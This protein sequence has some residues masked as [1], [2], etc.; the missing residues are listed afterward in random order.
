MFSR[1]AN[2]FIQNSKLTFVIVLVTL[3]VGTASYL[4]IPKQYNPTIIVPAFYVEV[5]SVWLTSEENKHLTLDVLEDAIMEV[6]G[7][8]KTYG[9]AWDN[10]VAVMV[11]FLVWVDK[12]KAKIRL[13]QKVSESTQSIGKSSIKTIDPD[14]LPQISYALSVSAKSKLSLEDQSIYLRKAALI[15]KEHLRLI[16]WTTTLDI[17]W[18][19]KN[20]IIIS[21]DPQKIESLGL[22]ILQVYDTLWKNNLLLPAWN[23]SQN[24]EKTFIETV[25]IN[26]H[27]EDIK[28]IVIA[29]K[30]GSVIYLEEIANLRNG[31]LE[32]NSVS[33]FSSIDG[34][35]RGV[36]I[37]VGKKI[38]TNAVNF[39]QTIEQEVEKIRHIIPKDIVITKIQD[40]WEKARDATSELVKDLFLSIGIVVAILIFFL[41]F[42][43]ALNTATSI[44]LILSLVFFFAYINGDNI[45]RITLFALI[46]VI[47]MLVDDSIVVVENIHRHLDDRIHTGK[48]KLQAILEATWEVGTGVILSTITKIIAFGA[49]FSVTGMMGEYMWPIPKYGILALLFSILVAFSINPWVSYVVASNV[50]EGESHKKTPSKWDIR[51]WY[52]KQMLKVIRDTPQAQKLRKRIKTVFWIWLVVV[53]VVPIVTGIFKARM[54]PKSNQNQV[55]IWIDTTRE[56]TAYTWEEV[57]KEVEKFFFENEALPENLQVVESISSTIGTP[58]LSDFSN[59]FRWGLFRQNEY[60]ISQRINLVPKEELSSRI[61]SE[62]FSIQ[63]RPLLRNHLLER[64][65]DIKI[66]LLE[67]PPG[68]PV[69]ATFLAK[70]QSDSS[71]ES[72][73]D[74]SQRLYQK[75]QPIIQKQDIADAGISLASTYKKL[76]I[77]IDQDA[78]GRAGISVSQAANTLWL[79]LSWQQVSLQRDSQNQERNYVIV[80]AE[81]DTAGFLEWLK[82]INLTNSQG[83]KIPFS[84]FIK[85]QSAF[86]SPNITTDEKKETYYIY[87]EM[88]DNSVVYP[89]VELYSYLRSKDFLGDEFVVQKTSFYEIEFLSLKDGHTY[90]LVWDGEWK[91]TMDTFRDLGWAM[92]LAIIFIYFLIVGQFRSFSIAW[93]VMLPFLL[94]F[95]G[96]FPWFTLLYL[97]KNEY[98]NATGMIWIISLAGIVV[99]NAILLI[100]YIHILKERWWTPEKAIVEAGYVR[101]MPIMLTSLSAILWAIKITSD[102][103]WSG[104]AWSIVWW[105]SSS[106]ILTLILLPIFYYDGQKK[107]WQ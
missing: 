74:F 15:I 61:S 84:T 49:M 7:I 103:V 37:G 79:L 78:V 21:L 28:K 85:A 17:V 46:L 11:Q 83:E 60:E 19:R 52:T 9:I 42:K 91:L 41:W 92:I 81:K 53:I 80:G 57:V 59:L 23:I 12:E 38:G 18:G 1:L 98:F 40:E 27:I 16:S 90:S 45:N 13:I 106:A 2:F 96:I 35:S 54:L 86:V 66:R 62:N 69:R 31:E 20:N 8:D 82:N 51:V 88:A 87:G 68:P 26:S 100:D 70:I 39:T 44:P 63:V 33:R 94:W 32:E 105:L 14:E 89:T 10:F 5:P 56:A 97:L 76:K 6:E 95:Y 3:F 34:S 64:F 67:D 22:D 93:V 47:W 99:G 77:I 55:Y 50:H 65:P 48:T 101:F 72:L 24:E 71:R 43:N 107:Y 25:W 4:L 36:F 29:S 73:K 58:F 104:L 75:I 30:D 102:P